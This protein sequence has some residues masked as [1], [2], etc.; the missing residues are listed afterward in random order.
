MLRCLRIFVLFG[1]RWKYVRGILGMGTYFASFFFIH[2][3]TWDTTQWEDTCS[4]QPLKGYQNV[5]K[6]TSTSKAQSQ[7]VNHNHKLHMLHLHMLV[8]RKVGEF[9]K[10]YYKESATA[11]VL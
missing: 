7:Y 1:K 8:E 5:K 11:S 6:S 4:K 3:G 2:A 9:N 10:V